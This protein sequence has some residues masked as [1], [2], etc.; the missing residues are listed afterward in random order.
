MTYLVTGG[1]GYIGSFMTKALLDRG[2]SVVVVDNLE[3][4]H[5]KV[6]D[7]RSQFINGDL[8]Y[9]EFVDS[10]FQQ[11]K[12][13]G[14]IH[15]AA[16]IS[17]AE[18]M[19]KPYEYFHNSVLGGLNILNAMQE[20][21]QNN[22]IFSSTAATYG[23]PQ[24]VPIKEDHGK[25]PTN[26]YGESKLMVEKLLKWFSEIHDI[27][28]VAL[29]YFNASGGALD[30]SMGEEHI[31]EIHIIPNIINAALNNTEFNL[32]GND[33][34]TPDGTCVRDYIHVLDLV[35]AHL[36][37]LQKLQSEKGHFAY[38][39]GTGKGY[40]NKEV[41]EM[42]KKISG[43]GIKVIEKERRPG[44]PATLV[45]DPTKIK[46]ELHFDPKYSDLETII[47]S[48]WKWHSKSS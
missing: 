13:D 17:V 30:G 48:A 24:D 6:I 39:V 14:V 2:D 20:N 8:R 19:K 40:S 1:A 10:L 28:S 16:Y 44:D 35:E 9:K 31:M 34:G 32:Y 21:N 7:T 41:V 43:R 5:Q 23:E 37:A 33:F 12:F 4:G 46:T 47:S 27:N 25:N 38:N 11:N 26:P 15:F 42:V 18:S 36:L 45:A 29:R 3:N 22:L